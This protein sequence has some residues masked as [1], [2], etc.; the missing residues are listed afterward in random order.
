M[1]KNKKILNKICILNRMEEKNAR[2]DKFI[3]KIFND[4][5]RFVKDGNF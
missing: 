3:I 5:G 1:C 4:S 2:R